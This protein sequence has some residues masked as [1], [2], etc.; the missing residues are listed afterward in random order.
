MSR[1]WIL[2]A[3]ESNRTKACVSPGEHRPLSDRS[4]EA[5]R[6][7]DRGQLSAR[8]YGSLDDGT[9][10]RRVCEGADSGILLDLHNL[11]CN[12]VN[13][14]ADIHEVLAQMPLDRVWEVHLAGGSS[15]D[16]VRLDGHW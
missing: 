7:R 14:R 6:I 2:A 11:W 13:G 9:Y 12:H 4:A 1:K 5:G 10:F 3:P 16:G 15:L 8:R